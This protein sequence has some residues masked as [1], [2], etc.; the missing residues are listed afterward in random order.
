MWNG[1]KNWGRSFFGS[2]VLYYLAWGHFD[3]WKKCDVLICSNIM[4]PTTN[5]FYC[6]LL[7]KEP[8]KWTVCLTALVPIL[9][10]HNTLK[11]GWTRVWRAG[12]SNCMLTLLE[13]LGFGLGVPDECE[14]FFLCCKK[15]LYIKFWSPPLVDLHRGHWRINCLL[16]CSCKSSLTVHKT[17]SDNCELDW[18][19]SS[20]P[21]TGPA[22]VSSPCNFSLWS[23]SAVTHWGS[24]LLY[25]TPVFWEILRNLRRMNPWRSTV[26]GGC[27]SPALHY[28]S[29]L[30]VG[31]TRGLRLGM[32]WRLTWKWWSKLASVGS[33]PR[34]CFPLCYLGPVESAFGNERLVWNGW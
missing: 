31:C 30:A 2:F 1:M 21:N 15:G 33:E 5:T 29:P 9:L 10:T 17:E 3:I 23:N 8:S 4:G 20:F 26:C 16:N 32:S 6:W 13:W 24:R 22:T 25:S 34:S 18:V 14:T 7:S 19:S 11:T 27:S 28:I 12:L